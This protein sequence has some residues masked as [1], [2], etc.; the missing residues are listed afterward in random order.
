M[1]L[2]DIVIGD[3]GQPQCHKCIK[4]QK[5]SERE[6]RKLHVTLWLTNV[7]N[8]TDHNVIQVLSFP[9]RRAT[10]TPS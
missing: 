3:I 1:H 10:S 8:N 7:T 2:C 4:K 9:Y 5:K 6:R